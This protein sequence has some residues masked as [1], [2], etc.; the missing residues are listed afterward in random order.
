MGVYI[1]RLVKEEKFTIILTT[2]YMEEA[3]FLCNRVGIIDK[4]KIIAD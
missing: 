2:Y 3:D 1:H 4:G